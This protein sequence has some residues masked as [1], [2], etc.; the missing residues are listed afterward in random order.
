MLHQWT[1]GGKPLNLLSEVRFA[2]RRVTGVIF[3]S[4]LQVKIAVRDPAGF[5][6]PA[7]MDDLLPIGQQS[8]ERGHGAWRRINWACSE[9]IISRG[10]ADGG[11]VPSLANLVW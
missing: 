8:A 4:R 2:G 9:P 6:A 10:D 11:H 3:E 5:P 1:T 7:H